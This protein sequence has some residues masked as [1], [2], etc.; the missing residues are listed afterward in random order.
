MKD[1]YTNA[2]LELLTPTA[3]A[4]RVIAGFREVLKARGHE[5]LFGP[6]LRRVHR[7]LVAARP[8]T[9]ITVA[10]SQAREAQAAAIAAALQNLGADP[11]REPA[12]VI[13]DTIIGGYIAE[14][15][16]VRTDASYKS[17]LGALYRR[18]TA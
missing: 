14:H 11:A 9:V 8:E 18:I 1:T 15:A 17:K 5:D 6:V 2:L 7:V 16:G 3:D 4:E 13:D 10:S 12:L